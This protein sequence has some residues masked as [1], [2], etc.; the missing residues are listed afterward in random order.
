MILKEALEIFGVQSISELDKLKIK[1]T[2]REL[3][4]MYH[5]DVYSGGIEKA[6][7][8]NEANELLLS[9]LENVNKLN[10]IGV[11]KEEVCLIPFEWLIEIYKGASYT[12]AS[13]TGGDKDKIDINKK[14]IRVHRVIINIQINISVNNITESYNRQVIWRMNDNYEVDIKLEHKTKGK[15]EVVKINIMNKQLELTVTD[16]VEVIFRFEPGIKVR[17]G[18]SSG[19]SID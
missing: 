16:H 17:L 14:S 2:Y 5:P 1:T 19:K 7:Q 18:L 13:R 9:I 3:M 10:L 15:E 6:Q 12:I 4:K 11:K 8:I